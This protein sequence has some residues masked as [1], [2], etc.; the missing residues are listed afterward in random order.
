MSQIGSI[1]NK[2]LSTHKQIIESANTTLGNDNNIGNF[3]SI[4]G[5]PIINQPQVGIIAFGVIRKVASVIETSNGDFLGIRK[6]N[7][8]ESDLKNVNLFKLIVLFIAL[9]IF[10][11]SFVLTITR[12]FL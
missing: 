3:G 4:M 1:T 7:D 6:K 11:I 5:T 9:N 12:I 10:F 8:L 2:V